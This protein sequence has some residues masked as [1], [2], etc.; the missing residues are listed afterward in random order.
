MQTKSTAKL[1]CKTSYFCCILILRLWNAEI[2]LHLYLAFSQCSTSIYQVFDG[3][4]E[5]LRVFNFA[6][7]SSHEI[8]KILMHTKSM[9]FTVTDNR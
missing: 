9:C 1:Y 6:I 8:R 3:Q 4:T 7:L 2:L 5:F